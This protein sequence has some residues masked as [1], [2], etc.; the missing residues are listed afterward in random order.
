MQRTDAMPDDAPAPRTLIVTG[1]TGLPRSSDDSSIRDGTPRHIAIEFGIV[2]LPLVSAFANCWRSVYAAR[3][4]DGH[5]RRV[6]AGAGGCWRVLAGAGGCWRVLAG[7]GRG[8]PVLPAVPD[9][10][11]VTAGA[12]AVCMYPPPFLQ[13]ANAVSDAA[14]KTKT[15]IVRMNRIR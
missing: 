9:R 7:A 5:R 4:V 10:Y 13:A 12:G 11:G 1:V 8:R 2:A 14:N 3:V 15:R 6:L